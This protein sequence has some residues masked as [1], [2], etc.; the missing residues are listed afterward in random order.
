MENYIEEHLGSLGRLVPDFALSK[1][2]QYIDVSRQW[3]KAMK[4]LARLSAEGMKL[5]LQIAEADLGI[6]VRGR[7]LQDCR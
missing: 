2:R 3:A 1:A 4:D 7:Q 5:A 6:S